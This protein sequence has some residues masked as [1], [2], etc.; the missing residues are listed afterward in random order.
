MHGIT[1]TYVPVCQRTFPGVFVQV[2]LL[3]AQILDYTYA[4]TYDILYYV[5]Y[6]SY[7]S[8]VYFY[9]KQ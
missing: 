7:T 8:I 2:H 4:N 5:R 9:S 6:L 1:S 3:Y